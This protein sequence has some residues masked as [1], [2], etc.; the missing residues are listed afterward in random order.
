MK[1]I[2][3]KDWLENFKFSPMWHSLN[4]KQQL[5]VSLP[6]KN[7]LILAGAGTGKTK[8]LVARIAAL[9]VDGKVPS[10]KYCH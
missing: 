8:T 2:K 5:A 7:S 9:I 10:K 4:E 3:N 1:D 6:N